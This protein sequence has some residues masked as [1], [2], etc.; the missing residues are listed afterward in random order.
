[1]KYLLIM[2]VDPDVWHELSPA[3]REAVIAGR[4]RFEETV[5]RAGEMISTETLA[6]PSQSSVVTVTNGVRSVSSGPYAHSSSFPAGYFLVDC[7]D[8]QRAHD[9]AAQLPDARVDGLAVEVRP[10]MYT[11]GTEM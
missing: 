2:H 5:S 7:D 6:D 11:G 8:K 4:R 9:L 10:V 3:Q 1:M